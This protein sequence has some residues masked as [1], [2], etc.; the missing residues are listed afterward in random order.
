MSFLY[1]ILLAWMD[2]RRS[3]LLG[4]VDP[5]DAGEVV[6]LNHEKLPFL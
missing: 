5:G 1:S 4:I 3:S 6:N 2:R